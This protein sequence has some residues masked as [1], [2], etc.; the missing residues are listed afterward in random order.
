MKQRMHDQA[1]VTPTPGV[2]WAR[3]YNGWLRVASTG[4]RI[5]LEWVARYYETAGMLCLEMSS[6]QKF[7][8]H[9]HGE[10][11]QP[12][13]WPRNHHEVERLLCILDNHFNP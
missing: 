7:A 11:G 10:D 9:P 13:A 12:M 6:G 3:V 5:R 1:A 8:F 4:D 2:P